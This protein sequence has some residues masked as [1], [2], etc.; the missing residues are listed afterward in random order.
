MVPYM[1]LLVEDEPLIR[2]VTAETLADAGFVVEEAENAT[3][4]MEKM[5][6]GVDAVI[7][8]LG[9]PDR[10]GDVL[11]GEIRQMAPELPILIAS[12]HDG[13]TVRRLFKDDARVSFVGK[14]Y[15]GASLIDA[16]RALGVSAP[17][18]A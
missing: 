1:I 10:P 3:E 6:A 13:D 17:P 5:N 16:L 11:A 12:G 4:A 18:A 14:P 8:D 2:M 9:L 7:I 15:T